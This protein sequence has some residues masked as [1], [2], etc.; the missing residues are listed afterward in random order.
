MSQFFTLHPDNPQPR[1]VSQAVDFL[2][3]GALIVYPT[4]SGYTLADSLKTKRP[5]SVFVALASWMAITTLRW[6]AAIF[7][8][9]P[10]IPSGQSGV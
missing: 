4:D 5:W 6:Y 10:P 7:L 9:Y 1:L 8:N 2:R 3:K